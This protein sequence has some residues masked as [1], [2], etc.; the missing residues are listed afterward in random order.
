MK[1]SW[2]NS[3]K[4]PLSSFGLEKEHTQNLWPLLKYKPFAAQ[5]Y[6]KAFDLMSTFSWSDLLKVSWERGGRFCFQLAL[7]QLRGFGAA[8][9]IRA[10]PGGRK[11]F[12][13]SHSA[14]VTSVPSVPAPS[15]RLCLLREHLVALSG[16]QRRKWLSSILWPAAGPHPTPGVAWCLTQGCWKHR[17]GKLWTPLRKTKSSVT[18]CVFV[19]LF[20]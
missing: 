18:S 8:S 12:T 6:N 7:L 1:K 2:W 16:H 13:D 10:E 17:K 19:T 11:C 20:V 15:S 3:A 4:H 9:L 5:L 14:T